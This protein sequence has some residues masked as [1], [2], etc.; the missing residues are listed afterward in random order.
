MVEDV[1]PALRRGVQ[2]GVEKQ[3]E[4]WQQSA[5]LAIFARDLCAEIVS[6]RHLRVGKELWPCAMVLG[7]RK[8]R[9]GVATWR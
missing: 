7:E 6:S 9:V 3:K 1:G 4:C 8:R 2:F 5:F